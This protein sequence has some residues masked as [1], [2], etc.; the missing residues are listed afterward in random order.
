V[1]VCVEG[2]SDAV[3]VESDVWCRGGRGVWENEQE[4]WAGDVLTGSLAGQEVT[5]HHSG[6]LK[7]SV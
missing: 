6:L 5:T 1:R 4:M 7:A 3:F 2:A